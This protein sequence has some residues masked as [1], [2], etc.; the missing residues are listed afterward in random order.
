[1]INCIV[2]SA[3][4]SLRVSKQMMRAALKQKLIVNDK[5]I[6]K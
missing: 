2:G 6:S 1:M 3:I 5:T 4:K